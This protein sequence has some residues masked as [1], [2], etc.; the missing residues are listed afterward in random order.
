L[1]LPKI[2]AAFLSSIITDKLSHANHP[3]FKILK[4]KPPLFFSS[5]QWDRRWLHCGFMFSIKAFLLN[6]HHPQWSTKYMKWING[7]ARPHCTQCIVGSVKVT[8]YWPPYLCWCSVSKFQVFFTSLPFWQKG[9][10]KSKNS[11]LVL[12][13]SPTFCDCIFYKPK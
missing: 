13:F 8:D 7:L 12:L 1:L 5:V 4:T 2:Q 6:L 10:T 3:N 9:N 11:H